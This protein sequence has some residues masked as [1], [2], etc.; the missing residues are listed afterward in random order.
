MTTAS[1]VRS[2]VNC[3]YNKP[4]VAVSY[5]FHWS[6][7]GQSTGTSYK[8]TRAWKFPI[9]LGGATGTATVDWTFNYIIYTR[10]T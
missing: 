10:I 8:F 3:S 6:C 1:A 9:K 7:S 5:L 2:P 4:G